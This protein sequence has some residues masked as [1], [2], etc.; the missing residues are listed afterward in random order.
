MFCCMDQIINFFFSENVVKITFFKS[1]K[2]FHFM[3]FKEYASSAWHRPCLYLSSNLKKTIFYESKCTEESS[4][5]GGHPILNFLFRENTFKIIRKMLTI[6]KGEES[7]CALVLWG[8][9]RRVFR[10]RY[11]CAMY[12]CPTQ[13]SH[14][15]LTLKKKFFQNNPQPWNVI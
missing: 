15:R 4:F 7:E 5:F 6:W 11:F 1:Y 10:Q 13:S 3:N 14:W 9:W 8:F 2:H 12:S